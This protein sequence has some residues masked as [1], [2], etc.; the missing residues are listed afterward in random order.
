MVCI[1]RPLAWAEEFRPVGPG[2]ATTQENDSMI[3]DQQSGPFRTHS[4][5]EAL[6][7]RQRWVNAIPIFVLFLLLALALRI[8]PLFEEM[9]Q[10]M[11]I[12][13]GLPILT[14]LLMD[15]HNMFVKAP[16]IF[17]GFMYVVALSY[18]TWMTKNKRRVFWFNCVIILVILGGFFMG[19][20]ALFLPLIGGPMIRFSK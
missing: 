13:P 15:C 3:N 17:S 18:L 2:V 4:V 11:G 5:V 12:V 19:L 14:V 7:I 8:I 1:P 6:T 20:L 16:W 9:Y 10:E